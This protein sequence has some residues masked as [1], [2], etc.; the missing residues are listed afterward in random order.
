MSNFFA[1]LTSNGKPVD[2]S[3]NPV[4]VPVVSQ[5]NVGPNI[6][7]GSLSFSGTGIQLNASKFPFN[8]YS[9][10][11]VEAWVN[12]TSFTN[13]LAAGVVPQA[14]GVMQTTGNISDWSFGP[15]ASGQLQFYYYFTGQNT[16]ISSNTLSTGTWTHICAQNDGT[17]FHMYINGVRCLGPVSITGTVPLSSTH[18]YFSLGQYFSSTG[19]TFSISDIRLV[20]GSNVYP[21]TGFTPP[22]TP[23]GLSP[24]GTTILLLQVPLLSTM[25]NTAG[26]STGQMWH[27]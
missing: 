25:F 20:Q 18:S 17:N 4:T 27:S 12:Y 15:N 2:L 7:E 26:S 1:S 5:S 21:V 24:V 23:L 8:W 13:A 6:Q 22:T 9:G 10:F 16:Q 19:P 11:T 14:M 3:S